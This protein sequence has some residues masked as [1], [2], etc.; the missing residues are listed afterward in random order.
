LLIT[1]VQEWNASL[2]KTITATDT[3]YWG[4]DASSTNELQVLS[5]SNDTIYLSNGGFAKLPPEND[6]VYAA[7]S[8][9][10]MN[11]VEDWNASV[12]KGISSGD[13]AYWNNKSDTM[14][15]GA[16]I[17]ISGDTIIN[18]MK[19]YQV[20]DFAHG[21]VVFYVDETGQHGL[22]CAK[23]DQNGGNTIQWYNGSYTWIGAHGDGVYA[24]EMNTMLIV[25]LLCSYLPT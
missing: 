1:G 10:L 11:G 16:N 15:A 21:G 23:M 2:A 7:D 20:G 5:I 9:F 22:V 3:I 25:L 8:A 4:A 14:I 19:T 24:G 12:A 18:T 6:P 17:Q 13:T